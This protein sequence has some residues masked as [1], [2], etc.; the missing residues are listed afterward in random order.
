VEVGRVIPNALL[1]LAGGGQRFV[2]S[3][4][5]HMRPSA[6]HAATKAPFHHGLHG[7][8]GWR[9]AYPCHP[10]DPWWMDRAGFFDSSQAARILTYSS[11]GGTGGTEGAGTIRAE[12]IEQR[13]ASLVR[14]EPLVAIHSF[15]GAR[16]HFGTGADGAAPSIAWASLGLDP[17]SLLAALPAAPPRQAHLRYLCSLL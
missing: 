5:R 6:A 9:L 11:T 12:S 13:P 10:C 16:Q 15:R 8:H 2:G 1:C 14:F 7:L 17:G 3:H 4:K